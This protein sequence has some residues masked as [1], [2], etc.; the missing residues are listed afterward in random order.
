[1]RYLLKKPAF[2]LI[3]LSFACSGLFGAGGADPKDVKSNPLL[4]ESPILFVRRRQYIDR[5]VFYQTDGR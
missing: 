5:N 1:M 3:V 4:S 2:I